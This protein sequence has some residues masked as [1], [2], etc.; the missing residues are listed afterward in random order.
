MDTREFAERV[1]FST[2]L[3]EK[4]TPAPVDL[5]DS[6]PGK[7]ITL[8]DVPGRPDDLLMRRD[9]MRAN[10]PRDGQINS[11]QD[12]GVLLHFLANHEL[13]ATELMALVLLRFPDAPAAFRRGIVR[14][15][16]EEQQHTR[17]YM[18]RM[19]ECGVEFGEL[20]VNGFFWDAVAPMESPLDYVTRLS[21][22]FEQANLDFARHYADLFL[23][24]GDKATSDVLET[25][26]RDEIAH[27]G[28]GLKW[29][30]RWGGGDFDFESYAGRLPFPLSPARAKAE[31]APFNA[32]G[33]KLAGFDADF[34]EELRLFRRSRGRTPRVY[35]YNPEAEAEIAHQAVGTPGEFAADPVGAAI[36]RDLDTIP[37]VLAGR[38]DVVLVAHLPSR[39]FLKAW[40]D[41][42]FEAP[43][44]VLLPDR[45][46]ERKLQELRPWA[47]SP[48]AVDLVALFGDNHFA[49]NARHPTADHPQ[50]FSKAFGIEIRKAIGSELDGWACRSSAEVETALVKVFAQGHPTAVLKGAYG[51][52]GRDACRAEAGQPLPPQLDRIL[53]RHGAVV[54]EPW[55]E[56]VLDFSLQ[57]DFQDGELK[58]V[59][60][61]RLENDP[62]GRFLSC[63][64]GPRWSKGA[65]S[66]VLRFL[67]GD[68]GKS[69][70]P[71][72]Q[73]RS[74]LP[75]VLGPRLQ[76]AGFV[77]PV[78]IDAFVY[79]AFDGTLRLNPVC[80]VNP[81]MTM[82]RIALGCLARIAPGKFGTLQ[83]LTSRAL[84]AG[85]HEDFASLAA[86][87]TT[88]IQLE[89]GRLSEGTIF[90]N[91]PA[92]ATHA[93]ASFRVQL[94]S[95]F[96]CR[97]RVPS[98]WQP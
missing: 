39:D 50:L 63:H 97:S 58:P 76:A 82:G 33:R 79:R 27:V 96:S 34:I 14:T 95:E 88:P 5:M 41:S 37:A 4:L 25:I 83:I 81:R 67:S 51:L 56:R 71:L 1:L 47:W 35:I 6:N 70:G 9:G 73:C 18:G 60:T 74:S 72:E 32:E 59:G 90:L 12:R 89:G 61:T 16:Q 21:L 46:P 8:P 91:D 65:P 49:P 13:L 3:E 29:S 66:E 87:L 20:P 84:R 93:L 17:L 23:H 52:A 69:T 24:L 45:M 42:G 44:F 98:Q 94:Y 40:A 22:T 7:A 28:Y 86:E 77:G 64:V 10:M 48:G 85:G 57:F 80:E 36:A 31:R 68:G 78:G 2:S 92:R 53:A 55:V 19:E 30:K 26:Y 54:V 43:E 11:D 75:K 15:L 38:D 62:L